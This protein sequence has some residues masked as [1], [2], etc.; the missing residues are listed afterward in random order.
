VVA[1]AAVFRDKPKVLMGDERIKAAYLG[2][3]V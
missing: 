3:E 2:G 1:F